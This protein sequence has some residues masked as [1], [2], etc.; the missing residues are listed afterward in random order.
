VAEPARPG[1]PGRFAPLAVG[2]L[3]VAT[4]LAF[5]ISQRLKREPLVVDRVDYRATGSGTDNQAPSVF[6]PNGDCRHDRMVIRFRTTKSDVADVEIVTRENEPVRSLAGDRFFKRYREHR[7]LWDGSTDSGQIPP[8]GRY[9]V[10][11]TMK[12]L[13]RQLRLPGWI[14][15]H[16]FEPQGSRCR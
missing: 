14:R 8:T 11:V 2:L 5:G 1:G 15:L 10:R 9:G 7:L 16:N 12:D 3:I 4:L 13:D 6:S